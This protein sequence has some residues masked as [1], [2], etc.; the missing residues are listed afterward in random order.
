MSSTRTTVWDTWCRFMLTAVLISGSQLLEWKRERQIHLVVQRVGLD[1]RIPEQVQVLQ[2][3]LPE[4]RR[5]HG[6]LVVRRRQEAQLGESA[7]VERQADEL[8]VVQLE[9]HQLLELAEL[10]GEGLQS[11]LAE[12]QQLEGPLQG[13]QAERLAEGL[14]VVV[15][16]DE[17]GEAAQVPDGGGEF[18]DVVVTEV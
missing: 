3:E 13:G 14:Q 11:V 1:K 17:L 5:Q 7:H 4:V 9:V 12:V 6:E 16:E 10:S 15:V 2:T 8:V 18:L